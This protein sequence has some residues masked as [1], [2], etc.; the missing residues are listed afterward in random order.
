MRCADARLLA[1]L[2][3][4][5]L[6]GQK[7][8]LDVGQDTTLGDGHAAEQLVQLLVVADGEL[9][10]TRDDS[11]LLVIAGGVAGQLEHF[12]GEVLHHRSQVDG[13][14]G[15]DTFGVVTLA[16]QTV[17]S[18]DWKLESSSAGAGLCLSL[19]LASFTAS[20]H[21]LLVKFS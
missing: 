13:R 19:D 8:S 5:S 15:S 11:R 1:H 21:L 14:A 10:V 12:G 9:Q 16:Q 2:R 3:C 18:A 4:R 17:D 6:L 20:R 7:H